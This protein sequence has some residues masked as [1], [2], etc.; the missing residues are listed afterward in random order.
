MFTDKAFQQYKVSKVTDPVVRAFWEKEMA[1]TSDFHK[2]E[3]L[4]YLI[5]K[6]GRFVENAQM[7][8]IIG[9]PKSGFN[10][11]DIMDK[12]KIL[13]VNLSKGKIGEVNSA[14]LGLIIVS[15]LQMA[16]LSR[17]D[18]PEAQRSDF[19]L[20]IDEFQNFITDSIAVI[21]SEARKYKLNLT[22]A[23]QYMGQLS[24]GGDTKVRD[25]VL[26]NVGTVAAFRIGVE[27]AEILER[28][29]APTF[30]AFDLVNQE[31]Y[32]AYIRLLIDNTAATPFHMQTYPPL[33]GSPTMAEAIKQ[34]SRL[35]YGKERRIV[36]AEILER[37]KLGSP[38]T[39]A[40]VPTAEASR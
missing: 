3:M 14:L 33:K 20:Y 19:F 18:M 6:V 23:H 31:Q 34:Y 24:S 1:K 15:K 27:D 32:T 25:A 16:A 30:S 29:F 13:L 26:G 22:M 2:S 35:R 38:S 10:L 37:T 7:R 17:A 8:N 12:K 21:L 28:Q 39:V 9:Q 4:G 5:S 40:A 36:E 11:R